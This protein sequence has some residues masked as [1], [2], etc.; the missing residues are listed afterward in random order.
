MTVVRKRKQ[1][2]SV[3]E[4]VRAMKQFLILLE[5]QEE[6]DAAKDLNKALNL[7]NSGKEDLKAQLEALEIIND[8]FEGEHELGAYTV[9]SKSKEGT[10][11][12]REALYLASTSVISLTN[13]IKKTLS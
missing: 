11:D 12:D 4:L 10:W 6:L 3:S 8:A 7:L 1:G 9:A 13:R 2:A 5:A